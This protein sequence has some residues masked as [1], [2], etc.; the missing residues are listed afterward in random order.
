MINLQVLEAASFN[1]EQVIKKEKAIMVAC[2]GKH[3]LLL[4]HHNDIFA[5]GCNS[6]G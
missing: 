2:G 1:K 4:S 5:V 6:H 3:T